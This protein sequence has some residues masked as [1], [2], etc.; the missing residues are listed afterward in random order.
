MSY[1]IY[2]PIKWGTHLYW[3]WATQLPRNYNACPAT[4]LPGVGVSISNPAYVIIVKSDGTRFVNETMMNKVIPTVIGI[5]PYA[6]L[7]LGG[8]QNSGESSEWPEHQFIR[9][10][11]NLPDRPRNCWAVTDS[12]G[13]AALSWPVGSPATTTTSTS[14]ST[15]ST[16]TTAAATST[17]TNPNPLVAPCLYPDSC[18]TSS[19][20]AGLA[21]AMGVS[22]SG[23]ATTV[24]NYNGYVTAGK[25]P[26][27][28]SIPTHQLTTPPYYAVRWNIVRHT[29]RNGIRINSKAQVIDNMASQW[30]QNQEDENNILSINQEPVIPHLYAAGENAGN[31]GWRRY[32]N[33]LGVYSIF[34]R[35]AGQNAAAE[36]SLA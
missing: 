17:I 22:A 20:L 24:T 1:I 13:A 19:T 18:A 11:L 21:L 7:P 4:G 23:L 9:A 34:G 2:L 6:P 35:I 15:T 3:S 29:Q 28:G 32:H 16:T 10:W 31:L 36:P 33:T 14:T 12:A 27:F 30:M 25:D 5:D 8:A 26:D